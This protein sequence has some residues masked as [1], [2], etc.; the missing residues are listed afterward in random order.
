MARFGSLVIIRSYFFLASPL[1]VVAVVVAGC[2][3][4]K[5]RS[6]M[7][8]TPS[9]EGARYARYL[10]SGDRSG[11]VFSGL[12]N[13]IS[14]GMSSSE[15]V[16]VAERWCTM[17]GAAL[18]RRPVL[19][20]M[21]DVGDMNA[22]LNI[23]GTVEMPAIK[24][25]AIDSFAIAITIVLLLLLQFYTTTRQRGGGGLALARR[26]EM[27]VLV[28]V[29]ATFKRTVLFSRLRSATSIS[30]CRLQSSESD[31]SLLMASQI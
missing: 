24:A 12:P 27:F 4:D 7:F 2:C 19:M 31:V 5:S 30:F 20:L 15:V 16:R 10:P 11:D 8:I 13:K 26:K 21:G 6:Q 14:R 25:A 29:T 18:C 1:V 23:I 9:G 22:E 28:T 3:L 17:L